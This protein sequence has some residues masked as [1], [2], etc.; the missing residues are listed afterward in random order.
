[1]NESICMSKVLF[2]VYFVSNFEMM[3]RD[4]GVFVLIGGSTSMEFI[5]Y[6]NMS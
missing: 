6:M 1:M 4:N 2:C 3:I 5:N